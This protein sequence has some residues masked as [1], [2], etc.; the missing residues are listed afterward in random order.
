MTARTSRWAEQRTAST[1]IL[2]EGAEGVSL[3]V[4]PR[5]YED[6]DTQPAHSRGRCPTLADLGE[7]PSPREC[8]EPTK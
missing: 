3:E 8:L 6:R 5:S 4:V 7:L 2:A 1:P